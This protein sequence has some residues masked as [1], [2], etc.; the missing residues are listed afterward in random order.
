MALLWLLG[1]AL[2]ATLAG[3]LQ[4]HQSVF[5]FYVALPIALGA[6]FLHVLAAAWPLRRRRAQEPA[7]GRADLSAPPSKSTRIRWTGYRRC[8]RRVRPSAGRRW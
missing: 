1:A 8:L 7:D 4:G 5:W 3:F 2:L 6:V